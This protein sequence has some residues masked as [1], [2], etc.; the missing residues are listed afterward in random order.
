MKWLF[1]PLVFHS[2]IIVFVELRL[3]IITTTTTKNPV[4]DFKYYKVTV[5]YSK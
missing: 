4:L 5:M 2:S 1:S 3:I